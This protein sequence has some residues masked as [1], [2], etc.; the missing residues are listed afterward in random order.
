MESTVARG[1]PIHDF[2]AARR[3]RYVYEQMIE[4]SAAPLRRRRRARARSRQPTSAAF[5]AADARLLVLRP[6]RRRSD[7][8]AVFER[9]DALHCD[10]GGRALRQLR[11][12]RLRD[13]DAAA[14]RL[15]GVHDVRRLRRRDERKIANG[16]LSDLRGVVHFAAGA[17]VVM[18]S[19]PLSDHPALRL[20]R[21]RRRWRAAAHDA[22]RRRLARADVGARPIVVREAPRSRLAPADRARGD[23]GV[24]VG[25]THG[26]V[27]VV[28][29]TLYP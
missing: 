9:A 23:G 5:R 17:A 14:R 8:D 28:G 15:P 27:L 11:V 4:T 25:G 7:G 22:R 26:A 2:V 29:L 16:A 3:R 19:G 20:R 10:P 18:T 12:G 24:R 1:G 13:R 21:A 6:A